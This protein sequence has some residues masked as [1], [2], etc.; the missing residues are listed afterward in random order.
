MGGDPAPGPLVQPAAGLAGKLVMLDPG[1]GGRDPG[2]AAGGHEE[3]DVVLAVAL[4]L[5]EL[6]QEAGAVVV[7]VRE[8]DVDLSEPIPGKMKLTDLSRRLQMAGEVMPD[9]YLSIHANSFPAPKW[10]GPQ[11]FYNNVVD[12]SNRVLASFLQEEL[13]A[14]FGTNRVMVVDQRQYILKNLTVPAACAE[15]G[16]MTNPQD[17][18]LMVTPDGQRAI[19]WALCRGL[20]K[21]FRHAP[22]PAWRPQ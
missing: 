11:V 7:M 8:T 10:R 13:S 14:S 1:H 9:V 19:A 20:A 16:F 6:L 12:P 2:A 15:I 3:K 5:R 21:Y 22:Q 4:T 18:S 17:L